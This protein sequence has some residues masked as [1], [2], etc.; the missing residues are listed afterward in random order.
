MALTQVYLLWHW[1]F[2]GLAPSQAEAAP[3]MLAWVAA[4]F[5]FLYGAQAWLRCYPEGR[6]A[7]ALYPWAYAGFYLDELFTRVTFKVW[8]VTLTSVQA[9]TL[10]N[11]HFHFRSYSRG[12]TL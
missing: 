1:L 12:E 10:A 5:G 7:N 11:R 8:P 3:L 9:Q 4:C 2:A 6:F